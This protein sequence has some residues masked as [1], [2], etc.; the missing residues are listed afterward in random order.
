LRLFTESLKKFNDFLQTLKE[1]HIREPTEGSDTR[2]HTRYSL[3]DED[4]IITLENSKSLWRID[5]LSYSGFGA[6]VISPLEGPETMKD[7]FQINISIMGLKHECIASKVHI[8][9]QSKRVVFIG[10]EFQHHRPETLIFL[11]K[12]LEPMRWGQSIKVIPRDLRQDR[13]KS[14]EWEC[15]RGDGPTDLIFHTNTIQVATDLAQPAELRLVSA[16]LTF[17]MSGHYAEIRWGQNTLTTSLST[18]SSNALQLREGSAMEQ[19]HQFN[20]DQLRTGLCILLGL[21]KTHRAKLTTMLHEIRRLIQIESL[22][23][24]TETPVNL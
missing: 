7:H 5:N 21:E 19:L 2:L 16:L 24:Y 4:A 15:L 8:K 18:Q 3:Q 17:P 20:S 10:A 13:Y 12:F 23:D 1:T 9:E 22:Q 6:R 11:R 14:L